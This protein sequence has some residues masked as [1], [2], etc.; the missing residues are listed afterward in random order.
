MK[1]PARLAVAGAV[2]AAA[3]AVFAGP[4]AASPA[5]DGDAVFVQTDG[6]DGN[7][8]VAYDGDLHQRGIYRTGGDGG[9][10]TGSVVDHL[11]SQ[12][13]LTLDRTHHLL[14]AVN[15]GSNT[16]T[17]F[18][19]HG[20]RLSRLQVIAS[21]GTFPV[22]VATHGNQV[23]V[24]NARAGGS[25]QGFARIGSR[26]V[27]VP[28]WHRDLGLPVTTGDQEFTH[29]P[30]E[31]AV[32][33]DGKHLV[34]TT[35]AAANSIAVFG[36]DRSGGPSARPA[37][38]TLDGA[39]PFAVTFDS[40]GRLAV[41]EAG[42]NAVATFTV[43]GNGTLTQVGLVATGQAAT[44]WITG[45]N[46]VLYASNAGSGTVTGVRDQRGELSSLGNTTTAA[47]SVDAAT[48][49]D[50]HHLYVQTGAAGTVV[51]FRIGGNG[52]LARTGSTTVPGAVG[53]EGIAVS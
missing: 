53:G 24:L 43:H 29:T 23:Y 27:K 28:S 20:T 30:G 34:V 16:V 45:A 11:A 10:L 51:S 46:G 19:V 15:A 13:S 38:T 40:G 52:S 33:P 18:G 22:S 1:A 47:G 4:A 41:A 26:L 35:K 50:G 42:P 37:V 48:S 3:T 8:I 44:C 39:V 12:G 17:V 31:I 14:Y 36:L 25:V 32:T 9:V 21:G 49:A 7:A 6:V 2:A 5:H